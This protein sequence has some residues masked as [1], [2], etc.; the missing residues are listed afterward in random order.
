M[1]VRTTHSR[2]TL[3][4]HTLYQTTMAD[5]SIYNLIPQPVSYD[6]GEG[7]RETTRRRMEQTKRT[8]EQNSTRK[9]GPPA[10]VDV[11]PINFLKK[12][13]GTQR[14]VKPVSANRQKFQATKPPVPRADEQPVFGLTSNRNYLRDN[15]IEAVTRVPRKVEP[16]M[17]DGAGGRILLE[18]SGLVPKYSKRADY[19]KTPAY[20]QTRKEEEAQMHATME[21]V[22]ER[23]RSEG[24]YKQLSEDERRTI[25]NGLRHNM[26]ELNKEY[27]GLP[28]MTDTAPK[29]ARKERIEAQLAQFEADIQKFERHQLIFIADA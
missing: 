10:K 15:A 13:G 4:L 25:L 28:V 5:E 23:Q 14:P 26:A 6:D 9:P 27:L 7:Q 24:A 17:Q 1:C 29:K 12:N 21:R 19:G 22:A 3:P 2:P 20:L 18:E 11:N 16:A 8:T